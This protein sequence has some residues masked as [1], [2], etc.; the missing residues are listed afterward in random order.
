MAAR[1]SAALVMPQILTRIMA[2]YLQRSQ[3]RTEERGKRGDGIRRKHEMRANE[4]SVKTGGAKLHEIVVGAQAG[5]ADGD[6]REVAVVYA[7]DAG[8][9]A[10]SA[11]ELIGSVNLDERLHA[12]LAAQSDEVRKQRI[13]K[14]GHDA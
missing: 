3:R 10:E 1:A 4:E 6:R 11:V 13:F 14:Y 12:Q 2:I 5:F 9:G 7:D 8:A